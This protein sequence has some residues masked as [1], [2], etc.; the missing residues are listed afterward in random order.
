MTRAFIEMD[1][2]DMRCAIFGSGIDRIGSGES[3]DFDL[4]WHGLRQ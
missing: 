1:K 4:S 2:S 3:A